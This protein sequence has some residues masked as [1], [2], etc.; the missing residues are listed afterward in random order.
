MELIGNHLQVFISI[1]LILAAI[2]VALVCDLLK[3]NNEHLRE[4]NAELRVRREEEQR[5]NQILMQ[6]AQAAIAG[7]AGGAALPAPG[8]QRAGAAEAQAALDRGSEVASR[9]GRQVVTSQEG[10]VEA[11]PGASMAE[12]RMLAREFMGRAA[13]RASN[14]SA[15]NAAG[16]A[17]RHP[18]VVVEHPAGRE[19]APATSARPLS[20]KDWN[21]ILSGTRRPVAPA[22]E[23]VPQPAGA[24]K[25]R[26][27]ELIP[28]ETIQNQSTELNVPEG[29]HEG[30]M[31]A[32]LLN[33]AKT[34]RG[35]VMVIGINDLEARREQDGE[36]GAEALQAGFADHLRSVLQSG[37]F[38]CQSALD[39]FLMICPDVCDGSA[40]QRLGEIAEALWDY[41]L[42]SVGV[43]PILFSWGAVEAKDEPFAVAVATAS[44]RM[45]ETRRTRRSLAIA[46]AP[47]NKRAV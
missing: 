14:G 10:P 21:K 25:S 11:Q 2:A 28:F 26:L 4:V 42:R 38:A 6:A 8:E 30:M 35:L 19:T 32:R 13:A 20:R 18:E 9:R 3:R 39:E 31:L 46:A 1:V 15:D 36:L 44:E 34:V 7:P 37:E 43:S 41:Q 40:Q 45:Q 47:L 22:V 29:F 12:A 23:V 17:V 33:G 5:R 27:G 24:P 16:R